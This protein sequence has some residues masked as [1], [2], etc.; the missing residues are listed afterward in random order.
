MAIDRKTNEQIMGTLAD[1][2]ASFIC[3]LFLRVWRQI[4]SSG[5]Y[6]NRYNLLYLKDIFL[7]TRVNAN[8]D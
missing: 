2:V 6:E 7:I 8:G 5:G 1:S 3:C 4:T